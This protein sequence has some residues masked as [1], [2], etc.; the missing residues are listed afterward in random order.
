MANP[1]EAPLNAVTENK[2]KVLLRNGVSRAR[3]V[4]AAESGLGQQ[5][6]WSGP[7]AAN[8]P[9]AE[10]APPAERRGLNHPD[11]PPAERGKPVALPPTCGKG[12]RKMT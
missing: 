11:V 7:V 9:G 5:G 3:R 1:G 2:P 12:S 4:A 6:R 10:G 8:S